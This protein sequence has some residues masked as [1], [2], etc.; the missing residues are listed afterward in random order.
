MSAAFPVEALPAVWR[1][2]LHP[3][4][5][6]AVPSPIVPDPSAATD[7]RD[8]I[9]ASREP[10]EAALGDDLTDPELAAAVRAHLAGD[11]DPLGAA[12][13]TTILGRTGDAT[14]HEAVLRSGDAWITEH[15]L[16]FAARTLVELTGV[17]TEFQSWSSNPDDRRCTLRRPEHKHQLGGLWE[18][19]ETPRRVRTLLT[20]AAEPERRAVE[21]RLAEMRETPLRR[22]M[23]SYLTPGRRDWLDECCATPLDMYAKEGMATWLLW[24]SVGTA[25]QAAALAAWSPLGYY[26]LEGGLLA[27]A[28][29]GIGEALVPYLATALDSTW[30]A[31]GRKVA[32]NLLAALPSD[33]AF[34]QL[35]DRSDNKHVRSV[36]LTAAKRHPERALRLLPAAP[37]SAAVANVLTELAL[38][39]PD[40]VSARLLELPDEARAVVR[41]VLDAS[42]RGPEATPADLPDLLVSPPWTRKRKAA[43]PVV[44]EGLVPPTEPEAA[45]ADGERARWLA[46]G[47]APTTPDADWA[48]EAARALDSPTSWWWQGAQVLT[49]APAD[50]ARPL[51]ADWTPGRAWWAG[52]WI[53]AV[54]ARFETAALP[55]L[56]RIVH[57]SPAQSGDAL[58][59][60]RAPEVARLMA[61]WR[62]RF[63]SKRPLATRWFGRHGAAAAR[64]LVPDAL[65]A[66][67]QE[68]RNAEAALTGLAAALGPD[69]VVAAAAEYGDAAARTIETLL[70][71]DPLDRLPARVPKPGAWADPVLLPHVLLRDRTLALPADATRHLITILAM[72]PPEEPYAGLEVVRELCDPASLAAFGRALFARWLEADAP[73]RDGWALTQLALT[74]DDETVRV[75]AP[76]IRAWPGEG[77]HKRA[78]S[79]LEV[80]AAIGSDTALM[81]LDGIARKVKF[82]ALKNRAQEKAQEVADNLGLTPDQLADRLVPDFGLDADGSLV[83][84][85][86]PRRFTVGF[87]ERLNPYVLDGTGKLRKVLPKPGASDDEALA[88]AAYQ[89]FAGLKKDVR[90]AAA[91]RLRRMEAA[92]VERRHWTSAEFQALHVDHP[93]AWHIAR[94]LVWFADEK[95][96]RIAEDRTFA[97]AQDEVFTL[98]EDA[99]IRIA[100]PIDLGEGTKAWAEVFADYEILQPFPQLTRPV[101]TLTD[102]ERASGRIERFAGVTVPVGRIF[103]ME[104]LG[105]ERKSGGGSWAQDMIVRPLPGGRRLVVGLDPGIEP[106]AAADQTLGAATLAGNAGLGALDPLLASEVIA[107]LDTLAG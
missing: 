80:L 61:D 104:H 99:R 98:P 56:L 8:W 87:D 13:L 105:W 51:L 106:G 72:S 81:H 33:E 44:L 73:S 66:P 15:G 39:C 41:R 101:H 83:L 19:R 6:G 102:A 45:W 23:V 91:A 14:L 26:E 17:D 55:L 29:E 7:L 40:L 43:K 60:F 58:L 103:G 107:E 20:A 11:A 62:A 64:L 70:S 71:G 22:A 48:A 89:R 42:A 84:D 35:V 77:S 12:G 16:E 3:R 34:A 69:A 5:G 4:P 90:T 100:H 59:P 25:E 96:F 24:A 49:H 63:K 74:G 75:L 9:T 52:S 57:Q 47:D 68:R 67:G 65:G 86:G 10:I 92:M 21:E 79:A 50:L 88:T 46:S 85:Y 94:R 76:Q 95:P 32:L 37:M 27:S 97:D 18:A 31:A 2:G 93:L 36:L 53:P 30:D 78:V 82:K 1:R 38:T 28:Y 54:A